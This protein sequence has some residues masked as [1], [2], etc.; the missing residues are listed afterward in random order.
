MHLAEAS[1]EDREVLREHE[2]DPAV[3]RPVA[4][5]HAVA[6][7]AL[8]VHPELRRPMLDKGVHLDEGPGIQ[9]DVEPLPRGALAL[10][11]LGVLAILAAAHLREGLPPSQLVDAL[12]ARHRGDKRGGASLRLR[13]HSAGRPSTARGV[14]ARS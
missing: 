14:K 5:D 4:R 11:P 10:R 8:L 1:A 13:G 2:H 7:D 6:G 3:D 9:Q 12:V